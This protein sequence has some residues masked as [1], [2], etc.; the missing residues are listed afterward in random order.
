[1]SFDADFPARSREL[2]RGLGRAGVALAWTVALW[3]G[4]CVA[5]YP[6]VSAPIEALPSGKSLLPPPP[7]NLLY[8]AFESATIPT[9]TRDGRPWRSDPG[10]KPD[11]FGELLV[12]GKIVLKTATQSSTLHPTWHGQA[13]GNY[14]IPKGAAV[15]IQLWDSGTFSNYPVCVRTVGDLRDRISNGRVTIACDSGAHVVLRV[16][17]PHGRFGLGFWYE[18]RP[19]SLV[20]TRVLKHSPAG[21]VQLHPGDEIVKVQGAAVSTMRPGQAKSL[22]DANSKLGVDLTIRRANGAVDDV[23]LQDGPIYPLHDEDEPA[24]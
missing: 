13:K 4:A 1:M 21:R 14:T 11:P 19:A 18:Q 15:S 2:R 8:V 3:L 17:P 9:L 5:S 24:D 6:E 12:N 10:S 23:T 16:E 7:A 20:I 22:I